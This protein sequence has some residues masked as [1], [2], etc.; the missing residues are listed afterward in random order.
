[1]RPA[2]VRPSPPLPLPVGHVH[3]VR[4][5]EAGLVE[6][7]GLLAAGADSGRDAGMGEA[8]V[9]EATGVTVAGASVAAAVGS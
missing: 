7:A 8:G 1:M 2:A 4:D 9:G 6:L 3:L 5:D